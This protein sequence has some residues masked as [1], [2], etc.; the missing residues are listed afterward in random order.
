VL[1]RGY[2]FKTRKAETTK[3]HEETRKKQTDSLLENT[4]Q[5]TEQ[6]PKIENEKGDLSRLFQS[7]DYDKLTASRM[8]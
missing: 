6:N 3:S 1:F 5:T 8:F 7:I 4:E 2:F